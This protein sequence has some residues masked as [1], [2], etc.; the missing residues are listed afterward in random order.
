MAGDEAAFTL[1]GE[2][3]ETI[4]PDEL[5]EFGC[6]GLDEGNG[7]VHARAPGSRAAPWADGGR[8]RLTELGSGHHSGQGGSS[9]PTPQLG[10]SWLA[11]SPG[12]LV[13]G[14]STGT[15]RFSAARG[16]EHAPVLVERSAARHDLAQLPIVVFDPG[17]RRDQSF[18]AIAD[19]YCSSVCMS[20]RNL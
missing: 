19:L 16:A 8:P 5:V 20:V 10:P 12:R 7:D 18:L 15:R 14:C 2:D 13:A 4:I 17:Q 1:R 3:A 6:V 9:V 11:I